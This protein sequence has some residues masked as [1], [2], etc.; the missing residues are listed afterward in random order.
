MTL[1]ILRGCALRRNTGL[2]EGGW[3]ILALAFALAVSGVRMELNLL[4]LLF[5]SIISALAISVVAARRATRGVRMRRL[6]PD[7]ITA[8]EPFFVQLFLERSKSNL[9]RWG[10]LTIQEKISEESQKD[11]EYE[12]LVFAPNM[13]AAGETEVGY[14][15][16]APNR[17][18]YRFKTSRIISRFPFG[19]AYGASKLHLEY[20]F[21]AFPRRGRLL[22]R[23]AP[24]LRRTLAPAAATRQIPEPVGEFHSLREY[25][26]GDS[27][28]LIH[29]RSS[30]KRNQL[31][32]RKLD[33]PLSIGGV[34][35]VVDTYLPD[36][37]EGA[38]RDHFENGI[39]FAAT[40]CE[41]FVGQGY[42]VTL[43]TPDDIT[44]PTGRTHSLLS[45]LA[46][47]RA[48]SKPDGLHNAIANL[49][50]RRD[51]SWV[52][53]VTMN[54]DAKPMI[55]AAMP[56]AKVTAYSPVDNN[57]ESIF[58]PAPDREEAKQ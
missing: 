14:E 47:M 3:G 20:S 25:R 18:R 33:E 21:I 40:L 35:L 2:T 22:R 28:H 34:A 24:P 31:L 37:S 8:G 6:L 5:S 57:F 11:D 52:V 42:N 48:S 56:D 54:S 1:Y 7:D 49:Q 4:I 45:R 43:Y 30:A 26:A 17:G 9:P 15:L 51:S 53:A 16:I 27:P 58:R 50:A 44:G 32:L 23:P 36:E 55:T 38:R 19:L 46:V 10:T 39:S 13:P 41:Y 12:R 29:W